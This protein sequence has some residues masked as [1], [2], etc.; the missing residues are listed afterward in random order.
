MQS[1][2]QHDPS[3]TQTARKRTGLVGRAGVAPVA[4][5]KVVGAAPAPKNPSCSVLLL[6]DVAV[7]WP[8]WLSRLWC[9]AAVQEIRELR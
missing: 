4:A 7:A 5:C 2:P 6:P 8:F 1:V 3:M 9:S